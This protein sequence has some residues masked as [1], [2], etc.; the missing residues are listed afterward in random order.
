MR[1]RDWHQWDNAYLIAAGARGQEDIDRVGEAIA[2]FTATRTKA[3]LYEAA[4]TRGL[5]IAPVADMADLAADRQLTA[6]GF[7]VPVAEPRVGR[8]VRFPGAWA[9]LAATPLR[10]PRPRRGWASTRR[11]CGRSGGRALR[12]GR[13]R[14][15]PRRLRASPSRAFAWWTSPG[16]PPAPSPGDSSP[17]SGPT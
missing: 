15:P 7:F 3:E 10:P 17:S 8:P 5:L 1:E 16:W 11:R 14:P 6:R 9:K 13:S 4:L 2:A 12:P